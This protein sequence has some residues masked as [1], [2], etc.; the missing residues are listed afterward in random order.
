MCLGA[1]GSFE[2]P[3]HC[4][5]SRCL[6]GSEALQGF[7]YQEAPPY[8]AGMRTTIRAG[9]QQRLARKWS[10]NTQQ[11]ILCHISFYSPPTN[12]VPYGGLAK[13]R[14]R[15]SG[16]TVVTMLTARHFIPQKVI[17]L[18]SGKNLFQRS[19]KLGEVDSKSLLHSSQKVPSD[20]QPCQA[21]FLA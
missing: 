1:A 7:G 8:S 19:L 21:W 14:G 15:V 18:C 12:S 6:L 10:H 4:C 9:S 3:G 20:S 16:D 11:Y 5:D 2:E 13:G 17:T